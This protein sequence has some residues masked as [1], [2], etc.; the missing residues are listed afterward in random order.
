[1]P[2]FRLARQ[3]PQPSAS[4]CH[5]YSR[6]ML[7]FF[8]S[9]WCS[10]YSQHNMQNPTT[11][12]KIRITEMADSWDSWSKNNL[13]GITLEL[14]PKWGIKKEFTRSSDKN[15]VPRLFTSYCKLLCDCFKYLLKKII[16]NNTK[17]RKQ[18][19]NFVW[20]AWKYWWNDTDDA[21]LPEFA[22]FL[23]TLK[24]I[25]SSSHTKLFSVLF[26]AIIYIFSFKKM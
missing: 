4:F 24:F 9:L 8:V 21:I 23:W 6:I 2:R 13:R 11:W 18:I 15:F 7:D 14:K 19:L 26:Q 17:W 22:Q 10:K 1:M 5:H 16:C 20:N 12:A 25:F 3:F